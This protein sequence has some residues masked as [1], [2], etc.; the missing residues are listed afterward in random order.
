MSKL[1]KEKVPYLEGCLVNE[2]RID[3]LEQKRAFKNIVRME[4]EI[5]KIQRRL[6]KMEQK[7]NEW[8]KQILEYV[9]HD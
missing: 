9:N 7:M 8:K 3:E 6:T 2:K 1:K 4:S 5:V